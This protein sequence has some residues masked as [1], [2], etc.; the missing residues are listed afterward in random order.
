MKNP[1]FIKL[2]SI[3]CICLALLTS[4]APTAY[5]K[6]GTYENLKY[7]TNKDQACI[8]SYTWDGDISNNRIVIP[9]EID[10]VPVKAFGGYAS[11]G[12]AYGFSII[13]TSK[14]G[15]EEFIPEQQAS[16]NYNDTALY[17]DEIV[18]Y[19][20][21]IVVGKNPKKSEFNFWP[22]DLRVTDDYITAYVYRFHFEV[23]SEN[24]YLEAKDGVLYDKV[25]GGKNTQFMYWN[26]IIEN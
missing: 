17:A 12:D 14:E 20:F 22:V 6:E 8:F 18:Y 25:T 4:C 15:L 9:D 16:L 3:S 19:D 24:L 7:A 5:G 13:D 1:K 10:G 23:D 11:N 2:I 26:E 21:D